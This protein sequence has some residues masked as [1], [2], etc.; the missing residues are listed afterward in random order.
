MHSSTGIESYNSDML[1]TQVCPDKVWYYLL[2][3]YFIL[4]HRCDQKECGSVL[5]F[6]GN[7]KNHGDVC[8]DS[9]AGIASFSGLPG[10]VRIGCQDKPAYKSRYCDLHTPTALIPQGETHTRQDQIGF[11]VDKRST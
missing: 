2:Y 6:N 10:H 5:V 3:V 7:M 1:N 11:I 8:F 9:S 4:E